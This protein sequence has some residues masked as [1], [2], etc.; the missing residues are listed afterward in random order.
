MLTALLLPNL[1]SIHNVGSLLRTADG[2]GVN[3]VAYAG[4]TPYPHLPGD[5]RLPHVIKSQTAAIHKTALGAEASLTQRRFSDA[6]GAIDHYRKSGYRIVGMEQHARSTP[7]SSYERPNKVLL[8]L[9]E[10]VDGID[11]S[12]LEECDD[13]IEIPMRGR[14]ESF[15]VSVAGALALYKLLEV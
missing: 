10:E 6:K 15:N 13:I 14:K 5:D 3:E 1:R 2:L 9:G 4:Y 8:V 7:L 11:S 12:V